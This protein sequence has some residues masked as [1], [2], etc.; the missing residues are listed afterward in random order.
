MGGA[1]EDIRYKIELAS[2]NAFPSLGST[3]RFLCRGEQSVAIW[4]QVARAMTPVA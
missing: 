4:Q 2:A 3:Y 1:Q